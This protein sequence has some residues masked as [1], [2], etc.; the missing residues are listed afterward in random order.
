MSQPIRCQAVSWHQFDRLV[1]EL[2]ASIRASGFRPDLIVAIARGGFVPARILCDYL[3]VMELASFRIEHYRGKSKAAEARIQ[4]PLTVEVQGKA[5]LVVD[6]LS[7]SGGTFALAVEYLNGL[8]AGTVR[9]AALHHKLGSRFEPDFCAKRI[10]KWRWLSYPWAR[11]EDVSGL[12]RDL[13]RPWGSPAEIAAKLQTRHGLRVSVA[14][15]A[16]A[17]AMGEAGRG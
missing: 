1:R 17:L 12:I 15:I 13:E 5:V 8:G 2:A 10:R 9:S 6:D 4:Q 3:E 11:L 14:T 7:D 16:D